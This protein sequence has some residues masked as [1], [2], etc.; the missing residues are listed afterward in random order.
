MTASPDKDRKSELAG[1]ETP[2]V[3][4]SDAWEA[5]REKLLVTEKTLTKARDA[6]RD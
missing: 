6:L 3:V 2:P 5:A 1:M 4:P